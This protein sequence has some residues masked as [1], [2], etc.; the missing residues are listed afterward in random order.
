MLFR[1][2]FRAD[3][4]R[5]GAGNSGLGLAISRAIVEAHGGNIEVSSQEN[6]GTTFTVRL[7]TA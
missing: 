4:S 6:V 2:F 1:R 5:A 3:P 7:P